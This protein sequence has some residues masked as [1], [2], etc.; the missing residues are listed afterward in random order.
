MLAH[1]PTLPLIIGYEDENHDLTAKDKR[2]IM[3]A[4]QHRNRVRR[5]YFRMPVPSL[6]KFITAID[7]DFPTLELL[8]IGPPTKPNIYLT[9]PPTFEAP[10]IRHLILDRFTSPI[11]SPFLTSAVGLV[12]LLCRIY[13]STYPHPNHLLQTLSLLPQLERLKIGFLYPVP[14]RERQMLLTPITTRVTL[15]NLRRFSFRGISAYFDAFLP[16]MTTP[17]LESLSVYFLNQHSFSIPS[18]L[19]FMCTTE[20]LTFTIARFSFYHEAV[21]VRLYPR[22]ASLPNFCVKVFC[23]HLER[24]VSSVSQVFN[25][26]CPLF[27]SV[28]DLTLDY[29]G[30]SLSPPEWHNEVDSA[31]WR[32]L[33]GSFRNVRT[34]HVHSGLISEVSRSLRLYGKPLLEPLPELKQPDNT[35][36]HTSLYNSDTI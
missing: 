28:V 25:T 6:Q 15:P 3:L 12:T 11:G 18:L 35:G 23:R 4:L 8:H 1:S 33:L 9:L 16:H 34:L 27:S 26:L 2:G 30:H 29:K 32:E 10:Q 5:I 19:Q 20:N 13:P 24:Q 17:R 21:A 22:V 7:G 31:R 14:N 36:K